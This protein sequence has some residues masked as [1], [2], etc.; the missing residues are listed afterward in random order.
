MN[1]KT[2]L[3]VVVGIMVLSLVAMKP[4][5]NQVFAQTNEAQTNAANQHTGKCTSELTILAHSTLLDK[6]GSI[7]VPNGQTAPVDI[8][9]A[10]SCGG[11]PIEGAMVHVNMPS[12]CGSAFDAR[13]TTNANGAFDTGNNNLSPCPTPYNIQAQYAGDSTHEPATASTG[14]YIDETK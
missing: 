4:L 3:F 13:P 2:T 6:S 12:N 10:L 7:G 1:N 8:Q 14:F 11:A 9:G 5:T